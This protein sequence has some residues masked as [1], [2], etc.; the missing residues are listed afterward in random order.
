MASESI[1]IDSA[2]QIRARGI[3]VKYTYNMSRDLS[4]ILVY[5]SDGKCKRHKFDRKW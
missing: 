1:A 2:E 4:L 3:I 5:N